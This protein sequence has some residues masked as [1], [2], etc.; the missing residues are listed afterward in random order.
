[1]VVRKRRN[2]LEDHPVKMHRFDPS[3]WPQ[4][5]VEAFE[6]WRR[7]YLLYWREN[8]HPGGLYA[9]LAAIQA[10]RILIA[11]GEFYAPEPLARALTDRAWH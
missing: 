2:A 9:L 6:A 7:A 1:M 11:T 10:G 5:P 8:R 4:S 3:E